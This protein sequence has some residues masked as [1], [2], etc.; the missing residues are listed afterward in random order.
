MS[1]PAPTTSNPDRQVTGEAQ[2]PSEAE[3]TNATGLDSNVAG[4]LS[5]VLG[6][7]TGIVFYVIEPDDEFVRFHAAQSIVTFGLLILVSVG[8]SVVATA[9]SLVFLTGSPG[10]FLVGGILSLVLGL[11]WLVFAVGSLGLW[12][13][14]IVRAY[15]GKTPRVPI[16]A[17]IADRLV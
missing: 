4:A 8:F 1:N 13:Y 16:A 5:Y 11:V 14:L 17:G 12:I 2:D 7:L 6:I 15:Q 9:L 3:S 10:G